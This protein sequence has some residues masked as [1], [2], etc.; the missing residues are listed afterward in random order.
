M[1]EIIVTLATSRCWQKMQHRWITLFSIGNVSHW[2]VNIRSF[3]QGN[4][5]FPVTRLCAIKVSVVALRTKTLWCLPKSA[6]G[7][8]NPTESTQLDSGKCLCLSCHQ[9]G[10]NPHSELPLKGHYVFP[11]FLAQKR[12]SQLFFCSSFVIFNASSRVALFIAL[13]FTLFSQA[14]YFRE[15][16][17]A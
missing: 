17:S 6:F 8:T 14:K 4:A 10:R 9:W 12:G 11:I 2:R 16:I 7:I 3:D 13:F 15:K 1:R 5:M